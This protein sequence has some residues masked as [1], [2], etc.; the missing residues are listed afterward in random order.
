MR[1]RGQITRGPDRALGRDHRGDAARQHGLDQL[2]ELPPHA[3]GATAKAEQ[4]QHHKQAGMAA[5]D[6]VADAAAMRQDQVA[7]QG[8]GVFGGDPQAGEF[9]KPGVDAVNRRVPG[10]GGFDRGAG[11]LDPRFGAAV[12]G[13]GQLFAV[14]A[15][16]I[17]QGDVASGQGQGCG[18]HRTPPMMRE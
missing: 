1:Q 12:Q 7:L 14:D 5:G 13:D 10:G 9:A 4:F 18:G 3:R 17:G 2:N 11:G 8:G 16:Q 15:G 6:G